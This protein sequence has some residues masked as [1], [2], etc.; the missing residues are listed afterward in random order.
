MTGSTGAFARMDLFGAYGTGEV[1]ASVDDP[2][3]AFRIWLY[4]PSTSSTCAFSIPNGHR[5][6]LL[7][8]PSTGAGTVGYGV[9]SFGS[10]GFATGDFGLPSPGGKIPSGSHYPRSGSSV[11]IW[12][13]W[14]DAAAPSAA[15]VDLGGTCQTMTLTRGSGTNGA[16]LYTASGLSGCTRYY[17]SFKDSGGAVVTYPSTGSLGIGDASCADWDAT[18]PAPCDGG[19]PIEP[20]GDA[21]VSDAPAPPPPPGSDAAPTDAGSDRDRD[22]ALAEEPSEDASI[23]GSCGCRIV[24][25]QSPRAQLLVGLGALVL[26]LARRS[27]KNV[28]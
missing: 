22:G 8:N 2:D 25:A 10:R 24:P 14:N 3:K 26:V 28:R 17:F 9:D 13:N 21:G 20:P 18:R 15:R 19:D 23:H 4:E 1:V 27:K 7:T 16:W 12:A 6:T 5:W 11:E